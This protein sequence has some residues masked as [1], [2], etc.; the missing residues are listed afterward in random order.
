MK[1]VAIYARV[2]TESQEEQKTIESQ[3][4]ELREICKDFQVVNEYMDEGWS[5][6]TLA[7]PSLDRLR[8]DASKGLFEA[9]YFHSPDRLAR[10]YAY[11]ILILDELKKKEIE[12]VFLNKPVSDNPEDQLLLGVQGLIAEYEKAKILERTRR[13]RLHK[14]RQKGIVGGYAPYGYLYIKRTPEKEEH[15]EI[16]EKEAKVVNLIFDLYFKI[17]S[18]NGVVKELAVRGIKPQR[19]GERW[20]RSTIGDILGDESYVGRGYYG[21]TYGVET[22]NGRKYKR[23]VKNSRRIQNRAEWIPIKFPPIIEENKL[24]IARELLSKNYKPYAHRKY[25][26]LLSGLPRCVSCGSTFTGEAKGKTR[27]FCYYRCNNRHKRYPLPNTCNAPVVRTE[28]LDSAVWNAVNE[29]IMKP[30]IL[31]AHIS[32]L[33]NEIAKSKDSLKDEKE[34]LLKANISLNGKKKRL[35]DL[36]YAGLKSIKEYQDQSSEFNEEENKIKRDLEEVELKLN[37]IANRPLTIESVKFFCDLA[38]TRIQNLTLEQRQEFLRDL[39]GVI[40]LDSRNRRAKII[41]RIPTGR[42]EIAQFGG[43]M[44]MSWNLCASQSKKEKLLF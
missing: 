3:L 21:K 37:Q 30:E 15:Y 19:G 20:S 18:I 26:Y 35:D 10:K 17:K 13:G 1:K 22:E 5:G 16:N 38:A 32:H 12:V 36:Y 9:V 14:A 7:R 6:G 28:D 27:R 39:L 44:S 11:Q 2:S 31:I 23:K 4:A 41:G 8:D 42:E 34:N 24:K 40:M 25:F 43:T 29:A 33:A